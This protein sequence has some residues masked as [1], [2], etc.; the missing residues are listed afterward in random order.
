MKLVLNFSMFLLVFFSFSIES[1][2]LSDYQIK[3]FC[4]KKKRA[5]LCIEN[6][7]EKIINKAKKYLKKYSLKDTVDLIIE[8][9]KINKKEI[10]NLCLKIKNE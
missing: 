2:S 5:S 4:A 8:T 7:Q 6:L 1:F 10:Y 3:R 9:E